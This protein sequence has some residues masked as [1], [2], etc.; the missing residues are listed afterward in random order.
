M[1]LAQTVVSTSIVHQYYLFFLKREREKEEKEK[2]E[3]REEREERREKK[4]EKIQKNISHIHEE[5]I[6]QKT[7]KKDQTFLP[8]SVGHF[9][10][11]EFQLVHQLEL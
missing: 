6:R 11:L 1:P 10:S 8:L 2:K 3:E 7:K 5:I 4:F 9:T